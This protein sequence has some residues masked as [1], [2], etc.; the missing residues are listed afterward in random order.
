MT[1]VSY[2]RVT[3]K[4]KRKQQVWDAAFNLRQ[5]KIAELKAQLEAEKAEFLKH[6][7]ET[8]KQI[9]EDAERYQL[10]MDALE[11]SLQRKRIG[12]TYPRIY[13]WEER[14]QMEK[15]AAMKWLKAR[16]VV[17][18]GLR[19]LES[20]VSKLWLAFFGHP[21]E[22]WFHISHAWIVAAVQT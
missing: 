5:K 4:Y 8:L 20:W 6:K 2:R 3:R 14:Q 21:V 12:K 11:K 7:E 10:D 1:I 17:V 22:S 18:N 13:T 19:E 16:W 9:Q 15:E